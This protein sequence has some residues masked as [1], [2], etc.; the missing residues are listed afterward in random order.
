L[1]TFGHPSFDLITKL[2]ITNYQSQIP[3]GVS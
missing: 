2:P 1:K 3:K